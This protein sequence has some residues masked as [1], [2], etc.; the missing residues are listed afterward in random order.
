MLTEAKDITHPDVKF[1][2]HLG[3][4]PLMTTDERVHRAYVDGLKE[5]ADAGYRDGWER[6]FDAGLE[7]EA[8]RNQED[9]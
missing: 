9:A 6:G 2:T 8:E 1:S 7:D 4:V 5:G 3:L